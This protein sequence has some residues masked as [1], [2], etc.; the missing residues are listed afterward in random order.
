MRIRIHNPGLCLL[1]LLPVSSVAVARVC[2]GSYLQL[3]V[4]TLFLCCYYMYEL[5]PV[6]AAVCI[7]MLWAYAYAFLHLY[8][9]A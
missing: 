3:S 1:L 5:L 9:V 2:C 6:F 4:S 7:Y 8:P